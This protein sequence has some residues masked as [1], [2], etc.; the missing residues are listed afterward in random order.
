[1]YITH[2][3]WRNGRALRW[4]LLTGALLSATGCM[5]GPDY[6]RPNV[7]TTADYPSQP[8]LRQRA[9]TAPAPVL[10]AWWTGFDDP[11]LTRIIQRVLAQNL[12]LAA[13]MARVDQARAVAREAGAQLAPQGSLDGQAV[14][15]QQSLKGPLGAIGSALPG[16][17]RD[18]TI[19]DL[20]VGAS[21]ELDLAGGLHRGVDVAK[22]EAQAAEANQ[23]GVRVSVAA[24][25]ADAY[26]RIRGAQDRVA[27][28]LQEVDTETRLLDLVRMRLTGGLSNA[29]EVAQAEALVMQSRATISPLQTEIARQS[30]RLDVLMG[31]APGTYAAEIQ[32]P[33]RAFVVP[34]IVTAGGPAMLLRR[35]PDVIAAEQRLVASNAAVGVALAEYYPKFSLAGMLGFESMQTGSLLSSAA[36]QPQAI[37]GLHWRL[38]DFGRVDAEVAQAKGAHAEALIAYRLSMLRATEDVEDSIVELANLEQQQRELVDEVDAHARARA[39]EEDAYKGGAVSLFEVLDEDRQLL[40]AR[41]ELARVHADDARAA[42]AT[43]RALGGGWAGAQNNAKTVAFNTIPPPFH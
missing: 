32:S 15:Q 23:D 30:N 34:D 42:V 16:Y 4:A 19:D 41:D 7:E 27:L 11:E 17:Q 5:V 8:L 43:F 2:Y 21:W 3:L 33:V 38:F 35:R 24:E 18:Q 25:A 13:A 29:R 14:R 20:G 31:M 6:A 40:A 22:A 36:F 26:F 9:V 28:A 37:L 39:A 10:D 12:D 1:M